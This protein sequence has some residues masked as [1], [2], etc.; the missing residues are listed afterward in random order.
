MRQR[1]PA[2][3]RLL[4]QRLEAAKQDL[5]QAFGWLQQLV[6]D[7][8]EASWG[9]YSGS[10][11]HWARGARKLGIANDMMLYVHY[12][13]SQ[14]GHVLDEGSVKH[15]LSLLHVF[16]TLLYTKRY[17]GSFDGVAGP[18]MTEELFLQF[19]QWI[20]PTGGAS[21]PVSLEPVARPDH[22]Q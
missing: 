12:I 18:F 16:R 2:E 3:V 14:T 10:A 7:L 13:W 5:P 22:P 9:P 21:R 6:D 17:G 11:A 20:K 19:Q 1:D 4:Y 8:A 15:I